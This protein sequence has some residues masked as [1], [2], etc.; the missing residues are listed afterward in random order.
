[1]GQKRGVYTSYT[2]CGALI[3]SRAI[4]F[5]ACKLILMP[6][7]GGSVTS[8]SGSNDCSSASCE[9]EFDVGDGFSETFTAVPDEGYIFAAWEGWG[10]CDTDIECN[11]SIL[12]APEEFQDIQFE[13]KIKATFTTERTTDNSLSCLSY[14]SLTTKCSGL[15]GH[16]DTS[17]LD[18][19]LYNLCLKLPWR[20][21]FHQTDATFRGF[22]RKN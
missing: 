10:P 7:E 18:P 2:R 15:W 21:G 14:A 17:L 12:P 4:S 6:M 22:L 20:G 3:G 13:I 8:E 11:V 16:G 19:G 9:F 1:M 5:A